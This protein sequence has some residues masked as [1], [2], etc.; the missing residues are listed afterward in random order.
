LTDFGERR[1]EISIRWSVTTKGPDSDCCF[2][3]GD[4]SATEIARIPLRILAESR[5]ARHKRCRR[6][7]R[8][9][10]PARAGLA[11]VSNKLDVVVLPDPR[12]RDPAACWTRSYLSAQAG[13]LPTARIPVAVPVG[14]RRRDVGAAGPQLPSRGGGRPVMAPGGDVSGTRWR[15]CQHLALSPSLSA[16]CAAASRRIAPRRRSGRARGMARLCARCQS[17]PHGPDSLDQQ[18]PVTRRWSSGRAPC[19]SSTHPALR[20]CRLWAWPGR[21]LGAGAWW[22]H[23]VRPTPLGPRAPTRPGRVGEERDRPARDAASVPVTCALQNCFTAADSA[24]R[25]RQ[26]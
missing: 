7:F 1:R 9:P 25:S 12:R 13:V 4:A 18:D 14:S 6:G 10:D 17:G 21:K 20:P 19:G 16:D 15:C 2:L 5:R 26:R 23:R 24:D 8:G 3:F 11:R 22:Q